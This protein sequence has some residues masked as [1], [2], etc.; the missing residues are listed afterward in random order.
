MRAAVLANHRIRPQDQVRLSG[1]GEVKVV[2]QEIHP[3]RKKTFM[4]AWD[5]SNAHRRIKVRQK[6]WRL[7]TCL[8]EKGLGQQGW[9]L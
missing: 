2:L 8:G 7:Q 5:A 6:D 9:D 1:V 4:P 3:L